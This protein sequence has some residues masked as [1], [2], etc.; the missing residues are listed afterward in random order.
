MTSSEGKKLRVLSITEGKNPTF[1]IRHV[2]PLLYLEQQGKIA[3]EFRID[4]EVKL[5]DLIKA[6]ILVFNRVREDLSRT[7]FYYA[8]IHN[9]KTIFDIDDYVLELPPYSTDFISANQMQNV[10]YFL[11]NAD[12]V[13]NSTEHLRSMFSS[14]RQD[15][16]IV[17]NSINFAKYSAKSKSLAD[18]KKLDAFN[19]V[20]SISDNF[21]LEK[22]S[23]DNFLGA[24]DAILDKY[25]HVQLFNFSNSAP[26]LRNVDRVK[27]ISLNVLDYASHKLFL[28]DFPFHLALNPLEI[29]NNNEGIGRFINSKSEIKYIEYA[30]A[31]VLGVYSDCPVYNQAV[32]HN[33]NGLLVD[34]S[35]EGWIT[36]MSKVIEDF[37]GHW[38]LVEEAYSDAQAKYDVAVPAAKIYQLFT[39]EPSEVKLGAS[40]QESIRRRIT[41]LETENM[42]MESIIGTSFVARASKRLSKM[43]SRNRLLRFFARRLIR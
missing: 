29:A 33:K 39:R 21:A 20:V 1:Y 43:A 6:D 22:R 17:P 37:D 34:N 42:M 32:H 19:I 8:K 27:K 2:E 11:I 26:K 9:K 31:K 13:T 5:E 23:L 12:I 41:A 18:L 14:L 4:K 15:I 24:I 25:P 40:G 3:V 7:F 36:T 28:R 38:P 30:A 10:H 35:K 16:E